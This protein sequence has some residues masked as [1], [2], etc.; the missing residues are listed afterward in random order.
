MA[1]PQSLL[2]RRAEKAAIGAAKA[3]PVS[4]AAGSA[5]TTQRAVGGAEGGQHHEEDAE[6]ISIRSAM[7]SRWPTRMSSTPSGVAS[8]AW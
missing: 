2:E 1:K 3:R 7:N 4:S 8:I 5:S 6:P